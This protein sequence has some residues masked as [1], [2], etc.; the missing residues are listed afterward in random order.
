MI[1]VGGDGT[2]FEVANGLV[3]SKNDKTS[4]AIIPTGS[5][6]DFRR[7]IGVPKDWRQAMRQAL[8]GSVRLVDLGVVNDTFF[9]NSLAIGFDARIGHLA[10]QIKDSTQK[11]GLSLYITALIRI[12][13]SDFYCHRVRFRI[14]DGEWQE[15][16]VLLIAANNG[17]SYGGG[18][19]ITPKAR[20]DDGKINICI[21]DELPRWQ[22]GLRLPFVIAGKHQWMSMAHFYQARS[23]IVESDCELPAAIDGELIKAKRFEISIRPGF[24][25]VIS[26][27]H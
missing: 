19:K 22:V 11:S 24:L 7:A 23:L 18:F 9:T 14:N 12:L 8:S 20:I 6:N 3:A 10:N 17:P 4:L 5:G 26:N 25:P 1:A 16:E 27:S 2:I 21:I 13:S 15:Q